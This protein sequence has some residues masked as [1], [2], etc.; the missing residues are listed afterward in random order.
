MT[1]ST[2][3]INPGRNV[4]RD[5]PISGALKACVII[6]EVHRL[7]GPAQINSL[8]SLPCWHLCHIWGRDRCPC[9]FL[10]GLEGNHSQVAS[11]DISAHP[12]WLRPLPLASLLEIESPPHGPFFWRRLVASTQP[13]RW[14][15]R[16]DLKTV[17]VFPHM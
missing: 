12:A 4:R 14:R 15:R 2:L 1:S 6:T 11:G 16:R 5:V 10:G 13:R 9:R 7:I 17:E 3:K 8:R